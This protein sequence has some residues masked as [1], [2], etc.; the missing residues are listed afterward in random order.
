RALC[1]EGRRALRRVQRFPFPLRD[2][3]AHQRLHD[4]GRQSE[5]VAG[6][7]GG[8]GT[9]ICSFSLRMSGGKP[10]EWPSEQALPGSK[11]G[12]FGP[13]SPLEGVSVTSIFRA[14]WNRLFLT[15]NLFSGP[16][17]RG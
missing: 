17:C 15:N 12:R 7:G 2:R 16:F 1:A 8:V 10:A 3:A 14:V 13:D 11:N 9:E 5:I 6:A 4:V